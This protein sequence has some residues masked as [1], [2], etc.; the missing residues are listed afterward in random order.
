MTHSSLP[1]YY[2]TMQDEQPKKRSF[3]LKIFLTIVFVF[4]IA[5]LIGGGIFYYTKGSL[6]GRLGASDKTSGEAKQ[7]VA[8][9]GKVYDLPSDEV[10]TIATVSDVSKLSGQEF[11]MRAKNGDKVL[12]YTKA[13]K[14]ILYRPSTNKIIEVGPVNINNEPQAKGDTKA[15]TGSASAK[16]S[17]K[18]VPTESAKVVKVSLLNGTKARAQTTRMERQLKSY[19]E[20]VTE[21][22]S[23][24]NSVGDYEE[25][26][27]ID[28]SGKNNAAVKKLA[29]FAKGKVALLPKVESAPADSDVLIILGNDFATQ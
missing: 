8:V 22:V 20:V 24:G 11:F 15:S 19:D 16:Q 29:T 26:V 17:G 18:A 13:K 14:A 12:I 5:I 25:T 28:L 21:V 1:C 9:V 2:V 7:L 23:K 10:P 4:V 27:V 6:Q 3:P